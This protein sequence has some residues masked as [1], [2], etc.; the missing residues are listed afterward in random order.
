MP[1]FRITYTTP[2]NDGLQQELEWVTESDWD[3]QRT[4][5]CFHKRFPHAFL[6]GL[7]QVER[8]SLR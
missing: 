1:I 4:Q 5:A 3:A 8:C 7:Q 6:L 2:L